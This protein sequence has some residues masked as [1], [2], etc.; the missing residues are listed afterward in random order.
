MPFGIGNTERSAKVLDILGYLVSFLAIYLLF[1][2][3]KSST[4]S[5]SRIKE[6]SVAKISNLKPLIE[7]KKD[8]DSWIQVMTTKIEGV[9]S[10]ISAD[11][12]EKTLN[13]VSN[14]INSY[15]NSVQNEEIDNSIKSAP[16]EEEAEDKDG[17]SKL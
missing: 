11:T 8:A 16:L 13:S 6:D 17:L 12:A 15:I 7:S 10:K 14:N 1:M 5:V 9:T 4:E 2:G 3:M